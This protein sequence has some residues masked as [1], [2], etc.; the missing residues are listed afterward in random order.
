MQANL[1]ALSDKEPQRGWTPP[2]I[3]KSKKTRLLQ[4]DRDT[5][6][7]EK[8]LANRERVGEKYTQDLPRRSQQK[9]DGL[10]SIKSMKT[11]TLV[12][13]AGV[14]ALLL[15]ASVLPAAV[16]FDNLDTPTTGGLVESTYTFGQS[17]G[18]GANGNTLTSVVLRMGPAYDSSGNF[19]VQLWDASGEGNTPG[20]SLATLTGS[21]NPATPGDYTYLGSY[22]LLANTTYYIVAGVS[23]GTGVYLWR[24]EGGAGDIPSGSSTIGYVADTGMGW[25]GPMTSYTFNM[26]VNGDF[27]PVPEPAEWAGIGAGLLGLVWLGKSWRDRS[28]TQAGKA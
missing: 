2:R 14:S 22:S 3:A 1:E 8:V 20:S 18:V 11:K 5:K 10:R 24:A 21:A 26:Q 12:F 6:R 19:F 15:S 23:G 9:S 13:R 4:R 17:F 25:I 27:T 28:R 16:V 7:N